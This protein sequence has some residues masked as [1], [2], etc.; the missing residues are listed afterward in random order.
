MVIKL[1]LKKPSGA[2]PKKSC[3]HVEF[4]TE[5][6]GTDFG[7]TKA[8]KSFK[9]ADFTDRI[10]KSDSMKCQITNNSLLINSYRQ[11]VILAWQSCRV[12]ESSSL[13]LTL[14]EITRE[15]HKAST[16]AC[17]DISSAIG[18]NQE[19]NLRECQITNN[20]LLINSYRQHVI[21]AWQSCRVAESLSLL[22]TLDV[23]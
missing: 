5:V 12:A 9:D 15:V 21:L 18:Q 3:K 6:E 20:S 8:V 13:L 22:L 4:Y 17:A 11:H 16:S 10:R 7:L 2:L 19:I 23:K 1:T 14:D